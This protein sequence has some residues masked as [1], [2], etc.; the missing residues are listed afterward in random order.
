MQI[1]DAVLFYEPDG[2]EIPVT[3]QAFDEGSAFITILFE[4]GNAMTR[5]PKITAKNMRDDK[6]FGPCYDPR[7]KQK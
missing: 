7:P 5:V 1:G 2:T 3:I 6:I 4:N